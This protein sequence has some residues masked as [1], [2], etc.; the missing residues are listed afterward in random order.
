MLVTYVVYFSLF[1]LSTE[2]ATSKDDVS[3]QNLQVL[4]GVT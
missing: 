2:Y 4:A 1:D 3:Q